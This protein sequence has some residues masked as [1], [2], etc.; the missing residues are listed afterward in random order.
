VVEL[1]NREQQVQRQRGVRFKLLVKV[2]Q[3]LRGLC[4]RRGS[5]TDN[6]AAMKKAARDHVVNLSRCCT[7]YASKVFRLLAGK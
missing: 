7:Q 1:E 5:N 4:G 2:E 6:L 3:N